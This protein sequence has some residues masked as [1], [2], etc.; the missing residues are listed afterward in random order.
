MAVFAIL[1]LLTS[2]SLVTLSV[3]SENNYSSGNL[4][5]GGWNFKIWIGIVVVS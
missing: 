2:F 1:L 5:V 3:G 4:S